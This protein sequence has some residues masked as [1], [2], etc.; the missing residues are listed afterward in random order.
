MTELSLL[1]VGS[2]NRDTGGIYNYIPNQVEHLPR[3]VDVSVYDIGA[4]EGSG[5]LWFL[6]VFVL[7][8]VDA[9][10]FVFQPKADVVHVHTSHAF[11]FYRSSFYVLFV[12][13]VWR[14]P[15]VMHVHGSSFD[16]FADTDSMP[17]RLYQAL[18]YGA[19]DRVIVLSDYWHEALGRHIPHRKL[20]VV[21]NAVDPSI[22]HPRFDADPPR[23]VFISDLLERK[24]IRELVRAIDEL[25]ESPDLEFEAVFAGKGPLADEVQALAD[26]HDEVTYLGYVTE[27]EKREMLEGGSIYV[28][29]SHAEGLPIAMLEAMAG[30]NAVVSTTVGAIP[31]VITEDHGLLVEPGD[32]DALRAAIEELVRD[33]ERTVELGRNNAELVAERYSWDVAVEKLMECYRELHRGQ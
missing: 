20:R 12:A 27:A 7:A 30:G 18:V 28:L 10:E 17:L 8:L 1:I 15:V 24:G 29:P 26:R 4:P 16:E 32:A 21:P 22:Y 3:D 33:P 13:L 9:V 14:R 5:T 23:I 19:T 31:E 2:N 25:A 11:S 6:K